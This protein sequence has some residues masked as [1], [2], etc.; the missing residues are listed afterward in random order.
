VALAASPVVRF[1]ERIGE[2][3]VGPRAALTR[4]EAQGGGLRDALWLVALGVVTFRFPL[5]LEALL[6]LVDPSLG[7]LGRVLSVA[8]V[9]AQQAAWVVIPAA[10]IVTVAAGRR[11]DP[12]RDL[13]LGAA[14]YA[15]YFVTRG[16][17]WGIGTLVEPRALPPL[18]A[19]VPAFVAALWVLALAIQTARARGDAPAAAV[20][21]GAPA[22]A[23]AP[24]S[25]KAM[26]V[27]LGVLALAATALAGNA[28]WAG[29]HMQALRPM[30]AGDPAPA[31][32]LPRIDGGPPVTL[33]DLRGHVVVL[34]FWAT[35]C[36]PCV[37]M[38]PVLHQLHEEWAPRGVEFLGV[39]S[40]GGDTSPAELTAFA[41]AHKIPYTV[42]RDDG[43]A[44]A[45]YKVRALPTVVV[46]SRDGTV[47]R[48]FLGYTGHDALAR[49]LR[50]A[51]GK[52]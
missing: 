34:D 29:K 3:L 9:E 2:L 43:R 5:L 28:A 44:G 1:A 22:G 52:N 45:L 16:L 19:Q 13:E 35:W 8:A 36:S 33:T 37:A 24:T 50:D 18:A 6:G 51:V 26:A 7:T 42:V 15:P 38:M 40:D 14:C 20:P 49:A 31:I 47:L 46:V 27:G 23:P 17:L 41:R 10:L 39:N 11:R 25:R 12:S 4:I 30:R 21:P 32:T 48:S